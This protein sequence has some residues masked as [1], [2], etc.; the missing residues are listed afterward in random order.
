MPDSE[1][2]KQKCRDLVALPQNLHQVLGTIRHFD[3]AQQKDQCKDEQHQTP[4]RI[5]SAS[6]SK[7]QQFTFQQ[8]QFKKTHGEGKCPAKR[9]LENTEL[10][11]LSNG[12]IL[13][14]G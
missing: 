7:L 2:D 5:R 14:N 4:Q 13:S 3:V 1:R 11:K 9:L 6:L 10:Q 12:P 8:R